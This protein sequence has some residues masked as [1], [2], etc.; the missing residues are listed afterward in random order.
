MS[1][2]VRFKSDQTFSQQCYE[3][4]KQEII[5]GTLQPGQKIKTAHIKER[6][7][8]GQSPIREALSRLVSLGLVDV[9]DN[10]GFRVAPLSEENIRDT[11]HTFARIENL[12]LAL[13]IEHGDDAWEAGIVG[14]LYQLERVETRQKKE[15]D[16]EQWIGANYNFHIALIV[17]CNSPV[18]LD[19]RKSLYMKFD[20]FCRLGFQGIQESLTNNHHEHKEL[21][22][23]VIKRDSKKAQEIMSQH[24][25]GALDQVVE[26]L[27]K[28]KLI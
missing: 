2:K 6:F 20:R 13:A 17:G 1:Q 14:A 24:I 9:A 25:L 21:A 16:L 12:A 10:K 28:Q 4:L 27:K 3:Q 8:I 22:A 7:D 26:K 18:L 23:A 5:D 19:V 15:V 11:Y